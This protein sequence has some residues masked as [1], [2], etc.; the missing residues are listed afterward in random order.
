MKSRKLML[1]AAVLG[2]AAALMFSAVSSEAAGKVNK[3][4]TLVVSEGK[5]VKVNYTL[6]VDGKV[7]DSSKGHEPLEFKAGSHEVVPG[8]EKAIMGMKVG[9]RKSFKV[10][11]DE[12]YGAINPKAIREVPRKELPATMTPKAGMTLYAQAKNGQR[13]PVRVVEVKKDIVVMDFNHPLAGKTLNFDV[14]IVDIK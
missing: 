7:V 6:K 1:F 12:G 5:S 10:S 13:F 8:F 14:E 3:G 4:S 11:P 9:E 2:F